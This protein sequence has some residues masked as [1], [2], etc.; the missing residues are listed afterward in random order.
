ME[1][2]LLCAV[3]ILLAASGDQHLEIEYGSKEDETEE[4]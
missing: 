3:I 2:I 4:Q 1:I